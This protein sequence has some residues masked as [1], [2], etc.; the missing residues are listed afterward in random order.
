MAEITRLRRVEGEI[1]P[2][3]PSFGDLWMMHAELQRKYD[4][5]LL[6]IGRLRAELE[7]WQGEH[8]LLAEVNCLVACWHAAT[9]RTRK[10][11]HND[12]QNIARILYKTGGF[13]RIL[14]GIAGAAYDPNSR[15][16]RNGT[17]QV[18]NDLE[19]I[20]RNAGKLDDFAQRAPAGWEPGA[21][22]VAQISGQPVEW[23]AERLAKSWRAQSP[24]QAR[25]AA[26]AA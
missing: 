24:E 7:E 18:Y 23:V 2:D 15:V 3:A 21:E 26:R 22:R 9:G 20:T 14:T 25:K 12:V 5:A 4:G 1:P 13:R 6:Q 19:L 11:D 8:H 17:K 16:R 10:P